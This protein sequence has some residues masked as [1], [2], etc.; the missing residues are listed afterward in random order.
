MPI[1]SGR[2]V[3]E[4]QVVSSGYKEGEMSEVYY[5]PILMQLTCGDKKWQFYKEGDG[6]ALYPIPFKLAIPPFY[7][8]LPQSMIEALNG[9]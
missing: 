4:L 6:Y 8:N 2:I 7:K 5:D 1:A 9:S 3:R